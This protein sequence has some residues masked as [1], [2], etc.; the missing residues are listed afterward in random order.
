MTHQHLNEEDVQ[1]FAMREPGVSD[2]LWFDCPACRE[3][4]ECY[5]L[6]Y[7]SIARMD[8]ES[9]GFDLEA[10]V[11]AGLPERRYSEMPAPGPVIAA[12]ILIG[13]IAFLAV[14]VVMVI[15]LRN[16]LTVLQNWMTGLILVTV[17]GIA[18][19]LMVD[20]IQE[21]RRKLRSIGLS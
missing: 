4:V 7:A 21:H 10:A 8:T 6:L 18:I 14:L 16:Y 15:L 13:S 20:A 3:R 17:P 19:W 5:R 11:L 9:A 2:A 12:P 1:L